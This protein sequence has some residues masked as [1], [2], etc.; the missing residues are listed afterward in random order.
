MSKNL[1]SPTKLTEFAPLQSDQKSQNVSNLISK[2]L[3]LYRT[4]VSEHSTCTI[5][6]ST[7]DVSLSQENL[8]TWAIDNGSSSSENGL[9]MNSYNDVKNERSLPNIVRRIG[10]LLALKSNVRKLRF[11]KTTLLNCLCVIYRTCRLT[12]SPS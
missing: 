2:F 9:N 11:K 8:P 7:G 3:N 12:Q 1:Q 4:N 5:E 6:D 10:N